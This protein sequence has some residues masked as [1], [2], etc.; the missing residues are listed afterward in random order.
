MNKGLEAL[1]EMINKFVEILLEVK[2]EK[3][4]AINISSLNDT[5]R[6]A[7]HDK[8]NIIET[9]LKNYEY[10]TKLP[11]LSKKEIEQLKKSSGYIDEYEGVYVD[12][13]TLKKLKAFEIIKTHP[14]QLLDIIETDN[15]NEYLDLDYAP[16]QYIGEK[17]Y[18]LVK[19]EFE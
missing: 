4:T 9:E 3:P 1:N 18:Y 13:N 7:F 17:D 15:Y 11:T 16:S 10:Q 2:C 12:E 14:E 8:L 19:E 6:L 5:L